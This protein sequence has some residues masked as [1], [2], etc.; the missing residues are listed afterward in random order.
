MRTIWIHLY[1][2]CMSFALLLRNTWW[3][4]R[5]LRGCHCCTA[6]VQVCGWVDR[7][8]PVVCC[9]GVS[10]RVRGLFLFS[11]YYFFRFTGPALI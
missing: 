9:S 2:C 7:F 1:Y 10:T 6:V 11:S 8:I 5:S 4:E 3:V